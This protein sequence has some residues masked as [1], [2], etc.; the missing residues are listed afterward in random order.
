[1]RT[2]RWIGNPPFKA[3]GAVVRSLV[4]SIHTTQGAKTESTGWTARTRSTSLSIDGIY[5]SDESKQDEQKVSIGIGAL[6]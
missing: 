4:V 3:A 2:K 5:L 6:V 1:M